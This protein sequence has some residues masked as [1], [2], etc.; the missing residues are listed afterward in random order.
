[1]LPI[2]L[3]TPQ[4]DIWDVSQDRGWCTSM[5]GVTRSVPLWLHPFTYPGKFRC[6]WPC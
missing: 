6:A 5:P 2:T 1:M 3:E 4:G